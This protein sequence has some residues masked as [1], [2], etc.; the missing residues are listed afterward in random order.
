MTNKGKPYLGGS[1][2]SLREF[3]EA[4]IAGW[5]IFPMVPRGVGVQVEVKVWQGKALWVNLTRF[6]NLVESKDRH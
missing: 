2:S 6:G 3:T 5:L 1:S 4:V